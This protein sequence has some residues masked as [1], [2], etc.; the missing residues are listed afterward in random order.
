VLAAGRGTRLDPLTRLV[1]KPAV[2]LGDMTLIE[3]VIARL[4]AQ[5]FGDLIVNLHHLPHTIAAV[6]GDGRQFGARVRYS[7]EQPAVLGSAGGPRHALPLLDA[8]RFL[9]VNGDTICDVDLGAL[10]AEHGRSGAAATLAVIPHP[11][12][13]R[14]GG[15]LIDDHGAVTG[16]TRKGDRAP[17]WHFVGVQA[18]N[19]SLFA[20]LADGVPIDSVTQVY[21]DAIASRP[22]SIR[23]WRTAAAFVDV[24]TPRDY[25][26]AAAA[27]AIRSRES[28]RG[29]VTWPGAFVP[30]NADVARCIVT[31]GV[32]VPESFS[33][34]DAMLLPSSVCRDGD[35]CD[36]RGEI[37]VFPLERT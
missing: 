15:V 4:A 26:Q 14:Y 33:A 12:P 2:P 35:R 24:G 9:I 3:H 19:A 8:Q 21:R 18:A 16:F 6:V 23:A 5:G 36:I 20:P 30:A 29:V 1:A 34:S 32:H 13:G 28:L 11:A 17:S 25:L 27:F 37:A 22:G 7:W 31:S 10:L